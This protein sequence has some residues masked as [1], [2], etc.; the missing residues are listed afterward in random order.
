MEISH[1]FSFSFYLSLFCWLHLWFFSIILWIKKRHT[2][3]SRLFALFLFC[4]SF[5]HVQHVF[6]QSGVLH[7]IPLF[8]P[9]CGIVLS[10]LG[11]LFYFYVRSL[12]GYEL[13]RADCWHLLI[14]LPGF[15]HLLFLLF[16]KT[17]N[18]LSAYYYQDA[19]NRYTTINTLLL[20]GMLLYFIA[21]LLLSVRMINRYLKTVKQEY[22]KIETIRLKWLK[23]LI[24]LLAVFSFLLCPIVLYMAN[25]AVSSLVIGYFSTFIYFIIVYK[26]LSTSVIF[27]ANLS[28]FVS[29]ATAT[30]PK[31]T[32]SAQSLE[33]ILEQGQ[34]IVDFLTNNPLLYHESLSLKQ[35]AD[36]LD[37]PPYV[38]SEVIN[39]YFDKSFFDL[40]NSARIEKAKTELMRLDTLNITIEG[41]G[42]NCGFGS[43]AA[44]YRAFKKVTGLT[45][46]VYLKEQAATIA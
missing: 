3:S 26:S 16:T 9:F 32:N 43:K 6:L 2:Y 20:V 36:E 30:K 13:K 46:T 39:R 12:T 10:A 1:T 8:D 44:F 42:Y 14:C 29:P 41:I 23:E 22:S 5:I 40:I 28:Q 34:L 35:M 31:Y 17:T 24:W 25:A 15:F 27:T 11:P 19:G 4:F 18:E 38:L 33:R 37:I 21:Y 7:Y 45:P